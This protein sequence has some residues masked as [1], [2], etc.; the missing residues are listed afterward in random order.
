MVV[1][2]HM[3][4]VQAPA[5]GAIQL[6]QPLIAEHQNRI[7]VDYQLGAFSW[8]ASL[9][10]LTWLQEMQVILPAIAFDELLRVRGT[11]ELPLPGAAIAFG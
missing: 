8:N 9:L 5:F 7:G 1:L 3:A 2:D 11:K 10:Q 6:L 4:P